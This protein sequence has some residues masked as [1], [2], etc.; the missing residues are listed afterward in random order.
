MPRDAGAVLEDILKAAQRIQRYT[1]SKTLAD[2]LGNELLRAGVEREFIIIG[3][4]AN[5]LQK[6]A[7]G[8]ALRVPDLTEMV[9][10][11]NLLAHGYEIILPERVWETVV[12][13]VPQLIAD[14]SKLL[15][16]FP[17]R[18]ANA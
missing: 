6:L 1:A 7:P 13:D 11:R 5:R 14:V 12:A 8:I 15:E 2:F 9:K 4:A 10:F 18:D 3:E 17:A 16:S